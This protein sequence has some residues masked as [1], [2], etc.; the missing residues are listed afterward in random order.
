MARGRRAQ[1]AGAVAGG[2]KVGR[3][4]QATAVTVNHSKLDSQ[5]RWWILHPL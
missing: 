3:S 5:D 4:G 2:G 1:P